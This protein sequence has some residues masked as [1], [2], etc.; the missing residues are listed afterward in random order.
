MP[1]IHG[2][3][4]IDARRIWRLVAKYDDDTEEILCEKEAS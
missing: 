1:K 4:I 2:E 3:K